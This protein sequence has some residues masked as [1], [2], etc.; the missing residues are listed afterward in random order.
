MPYIDTLRDLLHGLV[1][2]TD[3]P[4]VLQI[5]C[6]IAFLFITGSIFARMTRKPTV[7]SSSRSASTSS[8]SAATG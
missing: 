4:T 5:T 7:G 6:Y 8:S 2:Y 1:G 3:A